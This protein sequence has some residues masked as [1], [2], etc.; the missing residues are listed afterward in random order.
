[1]G[2]TDSSSGQSRT[3]HTESEAIRSLDESGTV[4][5]PLLLRSAAAMA[6]AAPVM[7]FEAPF[8]HSHPQGD[9]QKYAEL[10]GGEAISLKG[11]RV[12]ERLGELIKDL[13]SR[14]TIG[15]R[16]TDEKPAG[17]FCKVQVSLAP[18]GALRLREW[19]VL[20]RAGY[21]RK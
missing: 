4:V 5:T 7:A 6:W 12:E 10:T 15:Y 18:Y 3:V 14:Y 17:T 21:Y 8:R 16:P 13:R 9:A 2:R 11:K 19:K 20:A 1:M